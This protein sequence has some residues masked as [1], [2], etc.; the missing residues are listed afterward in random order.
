M[1]DR[2]MGFS[3]NYLVPRRP[4]KDSTIL[5]LGLILYFLT[6]YLCAMFTDNEVLMLGIHVIRL[7]LAAGVIFRFRKHWG[8]AWNA[9]RLGKVD[10]MALSVFSWA[11]G[12]FLHAG[13]SLAW[14]GL[15]RPESMMVS[16]WNGISYAFGILAL[17][18]MQYTQRN[19][20]DEIPR[21]NILY[22]LII[23]F[24]GI[25]AGA[26]GVLFHER[27]LHLLPIPGLGL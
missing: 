5:K 7:G 15:G 25:A 10:V 16:D 9:Y 17:L 1:I 12:T 20:N 24:I 23:L 3:R 14:R 2:I 11:M 8:P 22:T 4:Q 19:E 18:G 26:I 6:Y 27:V 21:A 13:Y